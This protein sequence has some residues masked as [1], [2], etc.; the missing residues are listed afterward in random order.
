[1]ETVQLYVGAQN[2]VVERAAKDLKAFKQVTAPVGETVSATLAIPVADLA[3]Y[4]VTS[5]AWVVEATTYALQVG[6]SAE[7]LPLSE[8]VTVD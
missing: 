2:S 7:T 5:K 6:S 3:Y 8:V 4:D 1:M